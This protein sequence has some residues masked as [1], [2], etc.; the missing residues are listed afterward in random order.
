[1]TDTER[2]NHRHC[3]RQAE[4]ELRA[5]WTAE[6]NGDPERAREHRDFAHDWLHT[7]EQIE[8]QGAARA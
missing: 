4:E 7:A 3:Y 2:D 5:A 8:K 6:A 1:M